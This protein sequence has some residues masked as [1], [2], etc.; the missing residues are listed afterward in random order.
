[1]C[2]PDWLSGSKSYLFIVNVSQGAS[3]VY[4]MAQKAYYYLARSANL[5]EGLNILP[6]VISIFFSSSFNDFSETNYLKIRWT[7]F[8]NLYVE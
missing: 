1:M 2:E 4:A 8:C 6:S 3:Q 5:P 7:D